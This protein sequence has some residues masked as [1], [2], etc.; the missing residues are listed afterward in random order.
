MGPP[1][2]GHDKQA[3]V[4]K[5]F[6]EGC[7]QE[8]KLPRREHVAHGLGLFCEACREEKKGSQDNTF[9][10]TG[11]AVY[12]ASI[13]GNSTPAEREAFV[14]AELA[15]DQQR[16]AAAKRAS[17]RRELDQIQRRACELERQLQESETDHQ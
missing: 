15:K 7:D 16:W 5:T 8:S 17:A 13:P 6:C 9:T 1:R 14:Q 4:L 3:H 10:P 12:V 2:A 11:R